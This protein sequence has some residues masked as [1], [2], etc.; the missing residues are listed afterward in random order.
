MNLKLLTILS[1]AIALVVA[2][3]SV[4]LYQ[5]G[6]RGAPSEPVIKTSKSSTPFAPS[7]DV[8]EDSASVQTSVKIGNPGDVS[9]S[10]SIR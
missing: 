7:P 6:Q 10:V 2:M 1:V 4:N 8:T 3:T 9:A 5:K